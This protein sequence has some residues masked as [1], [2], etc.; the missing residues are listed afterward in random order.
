MVSRR[1][2]GMRLSI[3]TLYNKQHHEN[4]VLPSLLIYESA[5]IVEEGMGIDVVVEEVKMIDVVKGKVEMV[6]L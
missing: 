1:E 5:T 4:K 3:E 6:R 2:S